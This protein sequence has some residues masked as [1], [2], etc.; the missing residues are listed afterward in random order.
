VKPRTR[1][2]ALAG[3]VLS[4]ALADIV[5][6]TVACG[7]P[8][9]NGAAGGT[10][11]DAPAL[12]PVTLPPAAGMSE[13]VADQMQDRYA[14]VERERTRAPG[15]GKAYAQAY[16]EL[17]KVLLGANYLDAAEPALLNAAALD[18]ADMRWPYYL[19]HVYRSKGAVR[20]S[21]QQ[22]ERVLEQRPADVP[23]LVWLADAY[24]AEGRL[25]DADPLVRRALGADAAPVAALYQS[26]RIALA[27]G[28]HAAAVRQFEAALN[29][30][31]AAAAIHY[32]LGLAYRGLGDTTRAERHLAQRAR[33]NQV[34]EPVDPLMEDVKQTVAGPLA[35]EVRGV[36]ALNR[37]DWAGAADAFRQGIALAPR[38]APLHHR[39]G[40]ALAMMGNGD[41]ARRE[42]EA[43]IAASP[44]YAKAHYSLGVVLEDRGDDQGALDRYAAA[45]QS[46]PD[47]AEARL[48]L[49]DVLRRRGRLQDALAEYQRVMSEN[50]A[51]S[52]A[53]LGRAITLVHLSRYR[54]ARDQ[55]LEGMK[56]YPDHA[57]FP[58]A[59][60]R[61]LAAAPDDSV[62]DGR[63]A[64]ALAQQVVKVDQSTDSG[65]TLGMAL[66]EAGRFDEAA[67]VQRDLIA[68][69]RQAGRSDLAAKLEGNL[70]L[71]GARQPSR[72]P[73]RSEDVG[74]AR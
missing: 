59:L 57:G 26:G 8:G 2:A 72:T 19:G 71:Y 65:E 40:T 74:D 24:I 58:H 70:R 14:A 21:A 31:P 54:E 3:I 5:L 39:L 9:R 23:A 15:D 10:S 20:E 61:V 55:L 60:A 30:D 16:G 44:A 69:A 25:D 34:V 7:S 64:L 28:D 52:D 45:V 22:F 12:R 29:R 53:M 43:A 67:A 63:R 18:P 73:W 11:I 36:E 46:A 62:R 37:R 13:S 17:G 33:E 1:A 47:Y 35:F 56:V 4:A 6:S 41:E 51:L 42:F 48:R 50:P 49:A 68:A 27:R 32:P 66:A 38:S